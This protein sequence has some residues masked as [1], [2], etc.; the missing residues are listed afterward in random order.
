MSFT[1]PPPGVEALLLALVLAAGVLDIRYRRI[2]N[3]L[4]LPGALCGVALNTF[5]Y[6]GWPGLRL[7][8]AG[9]GLAFGIYLV[10]YA[11]HA[12]SAGDVKLM[13]AIGSVVGWENWFGIFVISAIMGGIISLILIGVR[14]R[15]RKTLFNVSFLLSELMRGRSAHLANEEL[16]VVA[17]GTVFFLAVAAH[18]AK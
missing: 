5:L 6:Q 16:D 4:T 14:G 8:L 11:L 2:P 1:L 3:W 7:S 9:L 12:K 17:V 10:L 15:V 18:Y 13:A